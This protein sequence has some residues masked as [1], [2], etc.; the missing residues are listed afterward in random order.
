MEEERENK[1]RKKDKMI[2]G[3]EK[4]EGER[5]LRQRMRDKNTVRISGKIKYKLW[6]NKRGIYVFK[7][8]R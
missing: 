2:G 8:E 6:L 3:S 4:K 5:V 1:W 7:K